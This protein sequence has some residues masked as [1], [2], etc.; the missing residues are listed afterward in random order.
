MTMKGREEIYLF[1]YRASEGSE[2]EE[3]IYLFDY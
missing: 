2:D 1:D 3:E